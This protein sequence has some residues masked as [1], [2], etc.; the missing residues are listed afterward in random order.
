VAKTSALASQRRQAAK[1]IEGTLKA[2]AA[3]SIIQSYQWRRLKAKWRAA[4]VA[5]AKKA[6]IRIKILS[7]SKCENRKRENVKSEGY[8]AKM[9][10]SAESWREILCYGCRLL[11]LAWRGLTKRRRE[12]K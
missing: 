2:N 6:A 4:G 8:K 1:I 11:M 12:M 5:S 10:A 7:I 9:L 3:L